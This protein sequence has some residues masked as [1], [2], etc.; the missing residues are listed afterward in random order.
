[1]TALDIIINH[2]KKS[3]KSK[4]WKKPVPS[5]FSYI[6]KKTYLVAKDFSLTLFVFFSLK[7]PVSDVELKKAYCP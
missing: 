7:E 5:Y 3:S 6:T 1:M 2:K 4:I